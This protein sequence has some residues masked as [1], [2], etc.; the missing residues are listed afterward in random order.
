[1][2]MKT[3]KSSAIQLALLGVMGV[4]LSGCGGGTGTVTTT[5]LLGGVQVGGKVVDG[6]VSGATVTMDLNNDG[7]CAV[8]EPTA[9]TNA[10]GNFTFDSALGK[11]MLCS[12]GG[13]D[14]ATGQP[15]V[16]QIKAP[17]GATSVTPLTNMMVASGLTEAQ[18]V[19]QLG[20]PAGTSITTAD[21]TLAGNEKLLATT[22]AVQ[23]LIQQTAAAL[24][25]A[26]GATATSS[27]ALYKVVAA[28]V[29]ASLAAAPAAIDLTNAASASTL[30]SSVASASVTSLKTAPIAGV[31]ATT[32]NAANVAAVIGTSVAATVT[33][34]ASATTSASI[35]SAAT[36][37]VTTGLTSL[38]STVTANTANLTSATAGL[39]NVVP[40]AGTFVNGTAA[41]AAVAGGVKTA[42]ATGG[43]TSASVNFG[44]IVGT[45]VIAPTVSVAF[46]VTSTVAGDARSFQVAISGL[47]ATNTAGVL[48]F[49]VPATATANIYGKHTTGAVANTTA[50]AAVMTAAAAPW[51]TPVAAGATNLGGGI[52]LNVANVLSA[53]SGSANFA[54]LNLLKG[55]F[56]VTVVVSGINSLANGTGVALVPSQA[57]SVTNA[58]GGAAVATVSG[59]GEVINVT[60]N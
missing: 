4:S 56:N 49:A 15:F 24:S 26:T 21:P 50:S 20:L 30:A 25:T 19:T 17:A 40:G 28:S 36:T 57:V 8:G 45:P 3:F 58:A 55:N 22:T 13:T 31:T 11:H 29:A 23:Q 5:Q 46:D 34:I 44:A 10:S 59:Q 33:K 39:T 53:V 35:S 51:F 38:A 32:L 42:T 9:I 14:I 60:V 54:G 1:M 47:T 37:A 6:Y 2:Y 16:G 12:N 7:I 41:V 18:L 48:S 43:I 52:Q 27:D